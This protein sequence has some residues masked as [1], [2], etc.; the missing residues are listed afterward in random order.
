M[1]RGWKAIYDDGT[2]VTEEEM[3]WEKVDHDRIAILSIV[4]DGRE[5]TLPPLREGWVGGWIQA[6]T[7]TAV[8]GEKPK[9]QSRYVGFEHGNSQIIL[10]VMEETGDCFV[11]V[12]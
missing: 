9:I 12:R 6:K 2:V 3:H 10:R 7:A 8:M 4:R 1:E 5:Y 11:E